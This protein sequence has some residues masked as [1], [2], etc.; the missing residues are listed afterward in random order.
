MS[1]LNILGQ[2]STPQKSDFGGILSWICIYS[3]IWGT[4]LL[5]LAGIVGIIA[6]VV[7]LLFAYAPQ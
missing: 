3:L 4:V 6:L 5:P 7:H 1:S 2:N